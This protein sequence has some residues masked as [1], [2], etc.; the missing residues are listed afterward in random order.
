MN[1]NN[2]IGVFL[3]GNVKTFNDPV[4]SEVRWALNIGKVLKWAGEDTVFINNGCYDIKVLDTI[5]VIS[6]DDPLRRDLKILLN[7]PW[8]YRNEPCESI[9]GKDCVLGI[10]F[11]FTLNVKTTLCNHAVAYP[12][13][14][15][16]FNASGQHR[17][18]F[19]PYPSPV[20]KLLKLSSDPRKWVWAS[21]WGFA[22]GPWEDSL[23]ETLKGVRSAAREL[24]AEITVVDTEN[25]KFNG[26]YMRDVNY[27]VLRDPDY[28][29]NCE[30][31]SQCSL[32][33]RTPILFGNQLESVAL[34]SCPIV[35]DDM[36]DQERGILVERAKELNLLL[37]S[38]VNHKQ[39]HD[40]LIRLSTDQS[41]RLNAVDSYQDFL[42]DHEWKTA[43]ERLI[44]CLK[45]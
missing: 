8:S 11:N 12:Y 29:L 38:D 45:E 21:R 43:S 25:A 1:L 22:Q 35:F 26:A 6:Y 30:T 36:I 3:N 31:L 17:L 4:R 44:E 19:I 18:I 42:R 2:L 14:T 37:N 13:K 33:L 24:N 9:T 34:G 23:H 15:T 41:L 27:K 20:P 10:H 32:S 28:K 39:I 16:G 40:Q 5:P 7:L